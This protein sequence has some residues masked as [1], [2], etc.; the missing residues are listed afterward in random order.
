MGKVALKAVSIENSVAPVFEDVTMP[1]FGAGSKG[2]VDHA[3]AK[4]AIG[5]VVRVGLYLEFLHRLDVRRK[6]PGAGT[7][8]D[9]GAIEQE[10]VLACAG[11]V[12]LIGIVHVPAARARKT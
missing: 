10:Q 7:V 6:L 5:C 9:G 8:A 1:I 11:A 3:A 12:D 2:R 4:P